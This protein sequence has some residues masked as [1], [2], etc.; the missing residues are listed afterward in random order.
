MFSELQCTRAGTGEGTS[1]PVSQS[2]DLA[3]SATNALIQCNLLRRGR[4]ANERMQIKKCTSCSCGAYTAKKANSTC[5]LCT[6][7][8]DSKTHKHD[9]AMKTVL[10]GLQQ[11]GLPDV[12]CI[13][14]LD[15][16]ETAPSRNRGQFVKKTP[17][18]RADIVVV[19]RD[20]VCVVEVDGPEHRTRGRRQYADCAKDR[21]LAI[22]G[23]VVERVPFSSADSERDRSEVVGAVVDRVCNS[24]NETL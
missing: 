13:L 21:E 6:A 16:F 20:W 1:S 4:K 15:V 23:V 3:A 12:V 11:S 7:S 2:D 24:Y 8:S 5:R 14:E 9:N 17:A 10:K 22:K 19:V 18:Y